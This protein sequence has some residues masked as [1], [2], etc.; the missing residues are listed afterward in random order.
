MTWQTR[1]LTFLLAT[2]IEEMEIDLVLINGEMAY[3]LMRAKVEEEEEAS[4]DIQN[5]ET[6]DKNLFKIIHG[7]S[8]WNS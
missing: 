6:K 5:L 4:K 1:G 3:R 7:D 2:G 8:N